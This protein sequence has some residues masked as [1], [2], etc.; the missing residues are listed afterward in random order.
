MIHPD[1]VEDM[2][3]PEHRVRKKERKPCHIVEITNLMLIEE[4]Q[5]VH[6]QPDKSFA[7]DYSPGTRG[8]VAPTNQSSAE[9]VTHLAII[10]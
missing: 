10:W 9:R 3:L 1:L 8:P 7:Q 5:S 2:E 4:K 6:T